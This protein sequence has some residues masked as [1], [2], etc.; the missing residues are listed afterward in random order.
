MRS[1]TVL[2]FILTS[3]ISLQSGFAAPSSAEPSSACSPSLELSQPEQSSYLMFNAR[4]SHLMYDYGRETFEARLQSIVENYY[5]KTKVIQISPFYYERVA[6][7]IDQARLRHVVAKTIGLDSD[8][9]LRFERIMK[10]ITL[11]GSQGYDLMNPLDKVSIALMN[12]INSSSGSAQD[13]VEAIARVSQMNE[14]LLRW[15]VHN[16][17]IIDEQAAVQARKVAIFGVGLVGA[18]VLCSTLVVSAPIVSGAGALAAGVSTSPVTSA[19]LVKLAETAAGAA[20]GFVGA[21]AAVVT[22]NSY[23]ALSEAAKQ[24]ANKQT[25]FSCEMDKQI[26]EWKAKAGN[27]LLSAALTG[28]GMGMV[29]GLLTMSARSAQAVLYTTGF[30]VGVAQLYAVG[31]LSVTAV[32]SVAYYKMAE[33]AEAAGRHD[34]ALKY[35]FHARDLA[36]EAGEHGLESVI[37]ATLSYHVTAHFTHAL[38]EGESAIRQLYAASAD[39]LPTAAKAVSELAIGAMNESELIFRAKK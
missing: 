22:Q 9:W 13:K 31:K 12:A 14:Y 36:Q 10:D 6:N 25:E 28:A 39:T 1:R 5:P 30:G 38:R 34:L 20:I 2:T 18:G 3:F 29:G 27:S 16:G 4:L 37:I 23:H 35:L 7:L 17:Q 11:L 33:D 26:Q 15:R 19:I 32:Q 21:P 24:S 8:T